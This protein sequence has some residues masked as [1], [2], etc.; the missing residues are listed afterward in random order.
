MIDVQIVA[1][2]NPD[3]IEECLDR[4]YDVE[5]AQFVAN[6]TGEKLELNA[7]TVDVDSTATFE[8]NHNLLARRGRC[9][10]ILFLDDDAFL[11][12]GAVD[13]MLAILQTNPSVA[14]VGA[15]N[16]Q[17]FPTAFGGRPT[18]TYSSFEEFKASETRYAK[19]ASELM[20]RNGGRS[21]P[22][23]FLPGNCLLVRRKVWQREYGGWDEGY[24]NWNEEVDFLCWCWERGYETRVAAGVWFFHCQAQSRTQSG[25]LGDIVTSSRH[26]LKKWPADRIARL[27]AN[28]SE[29]PAIRDEFAGLVSQNRRNAVEEN[30]ESGS[31]FRSIAPHLATLELDRNRG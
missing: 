3:L 11:F 24:R 28:L 1:G 9:P 31:Y 7:Q 29:V 20:A 21:A 27:S 6:R 14:A 10:Y 2:K 26:F 8:Q 18:P 4:V 22:R 19:I 12:P 25:L 15:L 30:V 5:G 17:T 23:L 13:E 16:N